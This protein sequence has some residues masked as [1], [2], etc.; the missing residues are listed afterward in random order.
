LQSVK[1][2]KQKAI[3]Y[4]RSA[5]SERHKKFLLKAERWQFF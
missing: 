4:Q 2:Q 5:I 3:S 1:I